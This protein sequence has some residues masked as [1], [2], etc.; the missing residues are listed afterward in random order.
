MLNKLF[1]EI[2]LSE[3]THRVYLNLLENGATSAR[4]LSEHLNIPRPTIYD[5]LNILKQK[6]LV[7]EKKESSK[8]IFQV[9]DIKNLPRLIKNKIESLEQEKNDL[10]LILPELL[11]KTSSI[12]PKIKFYSGIEG[13]KQ[14]MNDM[15][16]Y[17]NIETYTMWSISDILDFLGEN[18]T[19]ELNKQRI[20]Q[21]IYTKA[22]WPYNKK[23]D[24]RKHPYLGV[25]EKFYREIRIA[26]KK[27][28][29]NMSYWVYADK[30]AFISS[31]KETF[32]FVIHSRD[33]A[34]LIKTQF[35][36][37]WEI[38]KPIKPEPG[39]TDVFLKTV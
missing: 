18:F 32:G 38:S 6:G 24:I 39:Y 17:R 22:I 12:E 16:W 23:V 15:L 25:G 13:V 28:S 30:V 8:K 14:V 20:R 11:N 21:S 31:K 33:F 3:N 1:K 2:G 26:P 5:S 37:I 34:E 9:D 7:I 19:K 4:M 29:W 10:D 35:K 27:I 36:M